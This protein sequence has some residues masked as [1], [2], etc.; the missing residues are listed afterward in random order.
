MDSTKVENPV[1]PS[2]RIAGPLTVYEV[3]ALREKLLG[4][5]TANQRLLL[6][7]EGI[8][9]C[10]TAGVQ[11]LYAATLAIAGSQK[12]FY[13]SGI[14]EPVQKAAVRI[15]LEAESFLSNA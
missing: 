4:F 3:S 1:P 10:D 12:E 15:G 2:F 5:I 8:T 14:P 11:F 9:D 6:D 13:I 7:I